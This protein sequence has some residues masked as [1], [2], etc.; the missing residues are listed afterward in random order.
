MLST[1]R[2][3]QP[4][5][6]TAWIT[7][8]ASVAALAA[9]F[10][11][12]SDLL[13][14]VPHGYRL[15][16]QLGIFILAVILG[17]LAVQA[18]TTRIFSHLRGT[19]VYAWRPVATWCLYIFMG[20]AILSALQINLTGL[21]AASAIVGWWSESPPRPRWAACSRGSCCWPPAPSWSATGSTSGPLSSAGSSN[22][23]WSPTW[24]SSTPPST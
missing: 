1:Q 20:L 18:I 10:A 6:R 16:S 15:V 7:V 22:S 12:R 5:R 19:A 4:E 9:L 8:A 24:E 23:G 3:T 14:L 21:L 11:I 2:P 17:G 13:Q